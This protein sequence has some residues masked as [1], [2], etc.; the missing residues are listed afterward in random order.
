MS[1]EPVGA[2]CKSKDLVSDGCKSKGLV[3]D[4]CKSKGLVSGG[5]N[6]TGLVSYRCKKGGLVSTA[7]L[8]VNVRDIC[9]FGG[10]KF[11]LMGMGQLGL[12]V[13]RES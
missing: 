9:H 4:G 3:S 7:E 6:K 11:S 12:T 13:K 10:H 2:G 5:C 8:T 1:A